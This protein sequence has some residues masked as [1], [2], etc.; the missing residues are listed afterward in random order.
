MTE[1]SAPQVVRSYLAALDAELATVALP[2]AREIRAG[3]AE[4][5]AGLDVNGAAERIE[6][7]GD[8]A[9]IAA[10]ARAASEVGPSASYVSPQSRRADPSW[11]SITA[12][13]LLLLG[14]FVVPI[15]GWF[16]GVA[17][18]WSSRG[19]RLTDKLV[20]T[21]LLPGGL[22]AGAYAWFWV[23]PWMTTTSVIHDR[24]EFVVEGPSPLVAGVSITSGIL[25]IVVPLA[26]FVFLLIRAN[27]SRA[28]LADPSVAQPVGR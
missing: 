25:A 11:Y 12:A 8:P 19:W 2:V 28:A 5:L 21:L 9:F 6:Q 23:A 13:M 1:T 4:E 24:V 20:G 26:T 27:R 22:L 3:I 10:E 15:V 7:L 14:A 17:M 18:L 16:A